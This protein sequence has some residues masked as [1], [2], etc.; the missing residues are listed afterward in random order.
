L[1]KVFF[2]H[3]VYHPVR[4]CSGDNSSKAKKEGLYPLPEDNSQNNRD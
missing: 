3:A 1:K 2:D 4:E